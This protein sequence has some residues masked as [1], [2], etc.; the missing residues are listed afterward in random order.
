MQEDALW[1]RAAAA[2]AGL[3]IESIDHGA[4]ILAA[5]ARDLG[6]TALSKAHSAI[7]GD[8]GATDGTAIKSP[9]SRSRPK[10]L[11]LLGDRI[12]S[13]LDALEALGIP[14]TLGHLDLNPGNIVVSP[15]RC[16]FLDWVEAYVGNPFISFQYLLEHRRRTIGT[17]SAVE[18][19][20]IE[21][22]CAQWEQIVSRA[23]VAEA[24]ALAPLLAVF[25][26][27]VGSNAWE[28]AE[29]LQEPATAGY[30]RSLTRRMN[31]EA[32]QLE[33]RRSLCLH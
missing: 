25:A 8:H 31:R 24:L 30:L 26:Y 1:E 9:A 19:R 29:R 20:L 2:L 12:Q 14:E 28:T 32:N 6:A 23:A 33:D 21:S 10:E 13:A 27:A 3:Q 17:D 4:R 7:H 15:N 11:L 5:G 16:V 22:Y 18:A